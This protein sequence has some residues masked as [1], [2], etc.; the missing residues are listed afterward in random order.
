MTAAEVTSR[1][2]ALE[3]AGIRAWV[4]AVLGRQTRDHA[5]RR[6]GNSAETHV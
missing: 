6:D 1:L 3:A 2:D 4:D 5:D